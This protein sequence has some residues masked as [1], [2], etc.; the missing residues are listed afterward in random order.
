MD[1]LMLHIAGCDLRL[2]GA[3]AVRSVVGMK[4]FDVFRTER[5]TAPEEAWA[6]RFG[7]KV[8]PADG[9]TILYTE[10]SDSWHCEFSRQGDCYCFTVGDFALQ[11]RLGS[12]TVEATAAQDAEVMR[13]ALWFAFS[14]LSADAKATP[15]HSSAVV[16]GGRAVL[17]L[18]ESGTGKSTHSRMWLQHIAGTRLLNDDSPVVTL[19]DG[20]PMAYGSPWSG[21]TPCYHSEGYPLHAVV[22][23]SQA[24]HNRMRRLNVVESFAALQ[25]SCPPALAYDEHFADSVVELVSDIISKVPV[26]RLECLPDGD[27]ARLCHQTVFSK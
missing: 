14:L 11:Y 5:C 12:A 24:P 19:Q 16:W 21:K 17:F 8:G 3:E 1:S 13:Y 2:E 18:G 26:Y 15:V 27:A 23:L 25:P 20:L 22:R 4:G 9:R 10:V 7:C 6:V